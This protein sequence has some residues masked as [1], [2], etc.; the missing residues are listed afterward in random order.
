MRL[1]C[2]RES[3]KISRSSMRRLKSVIEEVGED[4]QNNLLIDS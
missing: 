4:S 3:M 1:E 2:I